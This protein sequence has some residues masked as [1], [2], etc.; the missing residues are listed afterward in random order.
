M[1]KPLYKVTF[2]NH[3]KVYELYA[4]HVSGSSLWGFTEVG[5]LVFDVHEGLVV[6]P[7]EER[8]RDEFGNTR[9]LHLPM[10]SII[11]V[12]EVERK[13]QSAIRDA[14]TGEKVV[15]PFPLPAKPLR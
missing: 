14:A 10:Q 8:L 12:E 4:R 5:E 3:G 7:T 11:R 1:A 15:T 13:G 2:L 9:M 6:D